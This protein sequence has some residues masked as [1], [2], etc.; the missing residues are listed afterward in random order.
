MSLERQPGASSRSDHTAPWKSHSRFWSKF[1]EPNTLHVSIPCPAL[2]ILT[3]FTTLDMSVDCLI[4]LL[5]KQ[6]KGRDCSLIMFAAH[7]TY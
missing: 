5:H 6:H 1:L 4:P 7:S 2:S 3:L